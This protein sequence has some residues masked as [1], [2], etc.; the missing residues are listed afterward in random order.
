MRA[1]QAFS[2]GCAS[3]AVF[4]SE[5]VLSHTWY[6]ALGAQERGIRDSGEEGS[7]MAGAHKSA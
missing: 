4:S 6:T 7:E 3:S 1:I 5:R 2:S